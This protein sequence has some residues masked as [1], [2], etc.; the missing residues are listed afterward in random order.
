MRVAA[1]GLDRLDDTAFPIHSRK[2]AG[3]AEMRSAL[4]VAGDLLGR[5]AGESLRGTRPR[6]VEQKDRSVPLQNSTSDRPNDLTK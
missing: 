4:L 3:T 2:L 6:S 1:A 5:R